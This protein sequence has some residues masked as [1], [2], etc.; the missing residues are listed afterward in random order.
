MKKMTLDDFK[1]EFGPRNISV[2]NKSI[3]Y[4]D[5]GSKKIQL[6]DCFNNAIC[7]EFLVEE[8]KFMGEKEEVGIANIFKYIVKY[9]ETHP[10]IKSPM[11]KLIEEKMFVTSDILEYFS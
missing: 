8:Y 4:V 9:L 11:I 3:S 6:I 2:E 10:E 1:T 7:A 5:Y